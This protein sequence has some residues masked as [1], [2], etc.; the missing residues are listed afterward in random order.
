MDIQ[1]YIFEAERQLNDTNYYRI[2]DSPI[3]L[4]NKPRIVDILS[5]MQKQ[6]FINNKQFKYLSGPEDPRHRIFYLL[7]KIHKDRRKWT[8]ADKMPEGRPIVSDV[9]SESYRV[10]Q[11]LKQFLTPLSTKH[12]SYIKNTYDFVD[13]IR[14][15]IVDKNCFLITGD[16]S[17]L[18]T[19]MD[20]DRTI[21]CVKEIFNKYPD[22]NRPDGLLIDLLNI[23]LRNNDFQF[24]GKIYL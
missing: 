7:P 9:E 13:R 14:N 12:D 2:L 16:V 18:Y 6:G 4:D 23:T 21:N 19:N 20:H 3:F 22:G 24:N 17:A 1:N 15:Q 5:Q 11:L 10:S 8:I